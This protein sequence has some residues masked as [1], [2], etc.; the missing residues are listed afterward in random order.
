MPL[1]DVTTEQHIP[2]WKKLGLKLKYAQ[3]ESDPNT[4][5]PPET[6]NE[7]KR[8]RSSDTDPPPPVGSA[9][10]HM[11]KTK[12]EA[13]G[14]TVDSSNHDTSQPFLGEITSSPDQETPSRPSGTRKSVSFT[15]DTKT[16]DGD[17]V[18]QLY[19]TWLYSHLA[20]DPSFDPSIANS[21]LQVITPRA[22]TSPT[23]SSTW[24][25]QTAPTTSKA[26]KPKGSKR[27]KNPHNSNGQ[28][29]EES[30]SLPQ[31]A[32]LDYLH[33]YYTSPSSWKFSKS[34]QTHLLRHLF[35][36]GFVPPSYDLALQAYLSGLQGGGAK[37][38][39]RTTAQKIQAGG[40]QVP[41]LGDP[42]EAR[43]QG[44]E[45]ED[46]A[47]K[48]ES[49]ING[50]KRDPKADGKGKKK[51]G[52][53][54]TRKED[55]DTKNPSTRRIA[56]IV[57]SSIGIGTDNEAK[58]PQSDPDPDPETKTKPHPPKNSNPPKSTANGNPTITH[59]NP[60][61]HQPK[62]RKRKNKSRTLSSYDD[63]DDDD[64]SS[65]SSSSSS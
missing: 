18:K 49:H 23:S 5:Y 21:A 2:A 55:L 60:N 40:S 11:K 20:R 54:S 34:R 22:V 51:E 3:A 19:Q 32:T 53:E 63:D 59:P 62:K 48:K 25:Q 30:P 36:P 64:S 1:Q 46:D 43:M 39:L 15:P 45:Q 56:D 12:V 31:Q 26:K 13:L 35:S 37:T 65:S 8:K 33:T 38:R 14:S 52:D 28:R 7:K 9:K 17:S 4:R 6:V 58:H 61:P 47:R 24:E 44:V 27:L 57:L 10:K 42:D 50:L 16:T 29:A 41:D